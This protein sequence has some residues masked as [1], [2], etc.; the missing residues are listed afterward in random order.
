MDDTQKPGSLSPPEPAAVRRGLTDGRMAGTWRSPLRAS[1][2]GALAADGLGALSACGTPLAGL[3]GAGRPMDHSGQEKRV[4]FANWAAYL[5]AGAV[6]GRR[7][8]LDAF[9]RR[10]GITGRHTEDTNDNDEHFGEARAQTQLAAG[11]DTGR[12]LI[13]L[14]DRMCAR[15]TALVRPQKPDPAALPHACPPLPEVPRSGPG[16]GTCPLLPLGGHPGGHHV[17]RDEEH[18]DSA[19]KLADLTGA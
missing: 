17:P 16:P 1:V 12:G 3:T 7:P 14:T 5:G 18:Q 10:T 6:G 8:R 13:V 4:V 2:T 19:R 15:M 11:Q 9:T